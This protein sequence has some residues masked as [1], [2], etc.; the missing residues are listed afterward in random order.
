MASLG[1]S[2]LNAIERSHG[3]SEGTAR[4]EGLV[5]SLS[6]IQRGWKWA[7]RGGR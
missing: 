2:Y 5:G 1:G 6:G 3:T 7:V 4:D